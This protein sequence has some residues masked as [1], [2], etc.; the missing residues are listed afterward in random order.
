M[1]IRLSKAVQGR[2]WLRVYAAESE[3]L[4]SSP[5]CLTSSV[6]VGHFFNLLVPHL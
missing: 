4:G 5:D 2:T 1:N 3:S 6:N